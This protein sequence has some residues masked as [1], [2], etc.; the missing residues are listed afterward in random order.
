MTEKL[1]ATLDRIPNF[2][3]K[4]D[5]SNTYNIIKSFV[6][7][8]DEFSDEVD[9]LHLEVFVTTA[10]GSRLDDLGKIFKLSRNPGETDDSFRIRI[11]AY[12][13]GFSGGGTIYAIRSTISKIT[14]V[15]ISDITVTETVPPNMKIRVSVIIDDP[16]EDLLIPTIRE[17][18]W[19]IKAAGIYP[20]FTWI[21]NGD[22]LADGAGVIDSV[23]IE[24]VGTMPWFIVDMSEIEGVKLLW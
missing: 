24:Y 18:V 17:V 2:W 10:T 12:W 3:N 16:G 8:M 4:E 19:K 14:G 6:E 5:D 7:E 15:P 11:M 21:I 13:P 23:E 1:Y 22:L 9:N 20:F